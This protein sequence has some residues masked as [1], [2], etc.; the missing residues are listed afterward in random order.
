[1]KKAFYFIFFSL[2]SE[3]LFSQIGTPFIHT[4][5]PEEYQAEGQIWCAE[6]DSDGIMYFGSN[7]GVLIYDG[8]NW[9]IV[10]LPNNNPVRSLCKDQGGKI[11][12]GSVGEFGYLASDKR[13]GFRYVSLS[14]NTD[15]LDRKSVV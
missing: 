9:Q 5:L 14:K 6:Q 4:Y 1:M 12:V 10:K 15:S 8:S 2:I 13:N 7:S 3:I 11:Y